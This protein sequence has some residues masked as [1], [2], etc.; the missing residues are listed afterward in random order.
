MSFLPIRILVIE[1]HPFKRLVA[2]RVFQDLG[3]S[4]VMAVTN[5]AAAMEILKRTGPVDIVV[6]SLKLHCLQGLTVVEELSRGGYIHSIIICSLH[7]T[8]LHTAIGR[9]LAMHGV[10][11]L[12]YVD[13]PVRSSAIAPMLGRFLEKL[14]ADKV[15]VSRPVS[16]KLSTRAELKQAFAASEFKAFFQPKFNLVSGVVDSMEVL[17]RWE[18]P[19][20]G[21]LNPGGFLPL[22]CSFKLMDELFFSQLEQGLFLLREASAQGRH[23]KLAF[24]VQ[25]EQFGSPVLVARI[26]EL[27]ERYQV[28]ASR[29]TFEITESGLIETSPAVLESLIRL[30]MM[31]TG[32]S[33]D[34]FGIGF[35]SL[36]RLCQ[37]PFTEIKLDA[38]FIRDLASSV[39]NRAVVSSTLALGKALNM[40]VVVEGVETELQRRLL[41]QLGCIQAQGYL[42]ARPMNAER[43]LSWVAQKNAFI[44]KI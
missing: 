2:T 43:L 14:G 26:S 13:T 38:S 32:L 37:L 15:D 6:C 24:N 40:S 30:R 23:L 4:E 29:L 44:N 17:A 21:L 42:C 35:S 3:C 18:H 20:H 36:E 11:V 16:F 5:S 34:D 33:I 25:A 22:L 41:I 10:D 27:I 28:P 31:G 12:G 19:V 1:E 7:P 9:M 8:D 39:C